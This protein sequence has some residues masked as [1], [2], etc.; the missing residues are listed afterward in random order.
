MT[1]PKIG[2]YLCAA[3]ALTVASACHGG[4]SPAPL[5]AQ[6]DSVQITAAQ[7]G[8]G[9]HAGTVGMAGQCVALMVPSPPPPA[10]PTRFNVVSFKS[11]TAVRRG[12]Q[13]LSVDALREAY[14]DCGGL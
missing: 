10:A 14:G 1:L 7:L 13:D 2:S 9:W 3:T 6:G 11:V 5:L 4:Q 8:P 12:D